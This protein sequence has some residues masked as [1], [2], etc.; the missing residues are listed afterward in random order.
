MKE[1]KWVSPDSTSESFPTSSR[2]A[3]DLESSVE[4]IAKRIGFQASFRRIE[5]PTGPILSILLAPP[6]PIDVPP[7]QP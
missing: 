7:T 6:L 3:S 4:S 5:T 1:S 2:L